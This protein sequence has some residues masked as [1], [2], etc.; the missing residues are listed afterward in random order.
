[1]DSYGS[2]VFVKKYLISLVVENTYSSIEVIL[3]KVKVFLGGDEIASIPGNFVTPP[4]QK[5]KTW[6]RC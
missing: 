2:L 1:M 6:P 5:K 4:P 3:S